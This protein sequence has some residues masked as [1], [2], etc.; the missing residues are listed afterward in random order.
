[1]GS[2]ALV[3]VWSHPSACAL[4]IYLT[5]APLACPDSAAAQF[6]PSPAL[7]P[8]PGGSDLPRRPRAGDRNPLTHAKVK[9]VGRENNS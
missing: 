8:L 3:L 9:V 1:M 6:N 7:S 2:G 5:R 4:Q